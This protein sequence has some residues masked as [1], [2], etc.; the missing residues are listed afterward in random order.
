MWMPR[1]RY[2]AHPCVDI[3]LD[4]QTYF[5]V[6]Y[7]LGDKTLDFVGILARRSRLF[8]GDAELGFRPT[9]CGHLTG[10]QTFM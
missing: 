6:D 1:K 7:E 2:Q 3:E 9:L 4:D 8:C 5:F 10:D